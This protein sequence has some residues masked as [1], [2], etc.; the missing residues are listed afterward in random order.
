MIRIPASVMGIC[1][2]LAL[3]STAAL[4]QVT[5]PPELCATNAGPGC[6]VATG[7]NFAGA[8]ILAEALVNPLTNT[9]PQAPVSIE[10]PCPAEPITASICVAG[11]Q[12]T[13]G[14]GNPS[15]LHGRR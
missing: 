2:L 12:L 8:E 4:A 3:G 6:G 7:F 10:N 13:A 15:K 1:F 5:T 14:P 11:G 9:P